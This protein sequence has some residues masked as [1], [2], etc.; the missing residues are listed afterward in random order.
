MIRKQWKALTQLL[1]ALI[2]LS[3]PVQTNLALLEWFRTLLHRSSFTLEEQ[4]PKTVQEELLAHAQDTTGM[5]VK[6]L[7]AHLKECSDLFEGAELAKV[8][9]RRETSWN[10]FLWVEGNQPL[11][12]GSPVTYGNVLLGSIDYVQGFIA[13]VRLIFD[14]D[15]IVAVRA[16][17]GVRAI[18]HHIQQLQLYLKTHPHLLEKQEHQHLLESLLARA[19]KVS[20]TDPEYLAKGELA[21]LGI[22][23]EGGPILKGVGFQYE[24]EDEHGPPRDLRTG[25]ILGKTTDGQPILLPQDQIVTSGLDGLFPEGLEVGQI[26]KIFPLEEGS[27]SYRIEVSP[28]FSPLRTPRWVTVLPPPLMRDIEPPTKES[29]LDQLLEEALADEK[30]LNLS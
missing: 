10:S 18:D 20:S 5:N 12:L 25:E 1:F 9:S 28:Y 21:G 26:T 3:L 14:P 24:F 29:L 6:D 17:R 22:S 13:R 2:L 27:T 23:N 7:L 16:R 11:H 8:V 19:L 4:L 15:L 30:E